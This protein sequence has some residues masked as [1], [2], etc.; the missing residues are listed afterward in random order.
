MDELVDVL[1]IGTTV[2]DEQWVDVVAADYF[3]KIATVVERWPEWEER[4]R[5]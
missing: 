2:N 1:S 3:H 5:E 4:Y